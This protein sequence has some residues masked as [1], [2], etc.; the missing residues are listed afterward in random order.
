LQKDS[1]VDLNTGAFVPFDG[2]DLDF[3]FLLFSTIDFTQYYKGTALPTVDT[4]A[5]KKIVWGLPPLAEQ[6]RIVHA[7]E[8]LLPLCKKLGQ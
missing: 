8:K 5:V 3:L 1:L 2:I 6:K 7:I 4:D